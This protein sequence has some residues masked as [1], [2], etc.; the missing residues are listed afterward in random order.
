VNRQDATD[1]RVLEEP[2]SEVDA[3]ASAVLEAAVE[4]PGVRGVLA[5]NLR[6]LPPRPGFR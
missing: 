4:D 3:L 2:S 6:P 1:A 5:V